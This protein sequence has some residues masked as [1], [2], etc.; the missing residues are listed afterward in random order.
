MLMILQGITQ[1]RYLF[2]HQ[3]TPKTIDALN[4]DIIPQNNI[5]VPATCEVAEVGLVGFS[6]SC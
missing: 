4:P 1:R 3:P 6:Y 2:T 5:T